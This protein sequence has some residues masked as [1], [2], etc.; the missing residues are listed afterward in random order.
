M[1]T[2]IHNEPSSGLVVVRDYQLFTITA[3]RPAECQLISR[4]TF[5][6]IEMNSKLNFCGNCNGWGLCGFQ[7]N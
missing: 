5:D 7:V 4:S 6:E 1:I 2:M 3:A